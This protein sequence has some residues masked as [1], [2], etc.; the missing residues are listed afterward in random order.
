MNI[1]GI[2]LRYFFMILE[3]FFFWNEHNNHR[4]LVLERSFINKRIPMKGEH[5]DWHEMFHTTYKISFFILK[6][7]GIELDFKVASLSPESDL[8]RVFLTLR[9][10]GNLNA[11]LS[12]IFNFYL[13]LV[14]FFLTKLWLLRYGTLLNIPYAKFW[15]LVYPHSITNQID[16]DCKSNIKNTISSILDIK[17]WKR[18]NK[19]C[20]SLTAERFCDNN[21]DHSCLI[22]F[23][24]GI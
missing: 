16:V 22:D 14:L 10:P 6:P 3:F 1:I 19:S 8:R 4:I 17:D 18:Q 21:S 5:V 11:M 2:F 12:A 15:N 20:F 7:F 13:N 9:I 23:N 24:S